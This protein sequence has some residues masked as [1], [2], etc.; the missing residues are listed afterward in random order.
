[1]S[2]YT[3]ITFTL[4]RCVGLATQGRA[5]QTLVPRERTLCLPTLPVHAPVPTTSRLLAEPPHH[6]PP[7]A[8]PRPLPPP[9]ATVQGDHRRADAQVL[10]AVTVALLA[11]ER[12]VAEYPVVM[13]RQ[14]SLGH[15]RAELGRI[16]GG[17]EAD[18]RRGEEVAGRIASD[19]QLRPQPG[20]VLA[21]GPLE[22]V[23]GGVPA[24]QAGGI[25]GR[26]GLL[27]D[28]TALLCAR[29]G[30]MEEQDE[31]P[32]FSSLLAASVLSRR[33]L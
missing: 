25:D 2:K 6:L 11:V 4:T 21:T 1:M 16:V 32:F 12:R 33:F 5:E 13:D 26:C 3:Q 19:G 14:R 10:P 23:A 28:Q 30:A 24:L 7:V 18:S 27:A 17:A 8:A 15:D 9:V 31:R 29:G 20:I 22:E